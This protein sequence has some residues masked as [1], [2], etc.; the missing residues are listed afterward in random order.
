MTLPLDLGLV[1]RLRAGVRLRFDRHSGRYL[2]L[3]PE[4]AL[5]LNESAAELA[6]EC[7]GLRP[8][9]D[10]VHERV[11]SGVEYERA[12]RD[13]CELFFGLAERGLVE[14]GAVA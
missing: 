14:W 4:R 2:L 5:L 9:I 13:V 10:L 3:S 7:D 8:L 1:P 6:C 12:R 11:R